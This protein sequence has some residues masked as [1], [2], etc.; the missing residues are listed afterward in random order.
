MECAIDL[1]K[2]CQNHLLC[3]YFIGH[4]GFQKHM[5]RYDHGASY[6]LLEGQQILEVRLHT[7]LLQLSVSM[8]STSK[9]QAI[10]LSCF[11]QE[12]KCVSRSSQILLMR[13]AVYR[14]SMKIV[15]GLPCMSQRRTLFVRMASCRCQ[16]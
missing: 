15:E 5:E 9:S 4:T 8:K 11:P 16:L 10:F 2:K 14:I 7:S 1:A 13:K 12:A 6:K 3:G